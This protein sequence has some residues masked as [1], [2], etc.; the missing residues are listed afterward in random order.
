MNKL[1]YMAL[2]GA[3][4]YQNVQ[5]MKF[6]MGDYKYRD[7]SFVQTFENQNAT[8][9]D[10]ATANQ[11]LSQSNLT[12]NAT[13]DDKDIENYYNATKE[14]DDFFSSFLHKSTNKT[15]NANTTKNTTA[16]ITANITKNTTANATSNVTK[17][18]TMN[19]SKP[20]LVQKPTLLNAENLNN[21]NKMV[22][23]D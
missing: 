17:N 1:V 4:S 18:A 16:N 15:A 2:V 21:M 13:S 11:T 8:I 5:A 14:Q 22:K 3:V 6:N 19:V 10:N 9:G 7:V 23:A 20:A 12:S